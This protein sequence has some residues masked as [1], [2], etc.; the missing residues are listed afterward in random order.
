VT[1]RA[2]ATAL[3]TLAMLNVFTLGAGVAVAGLLPARLA[4]WQVPRVARSRLETPGQV[5]APASPRGPAPDRARLAA[6]LA[7]MLAGRPLGGHVGAVVTDLDTGAVLFSQN[8]GSEF[9]PASNAKL[10]TAV[11]ALSTLGPPARFTTR[12]VAGARPGLLTLVGGGDPTLA[13]GPPPRGDYPR[14]ASQWAVEAAS[15]ASVAGCG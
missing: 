5:L 13:A 10:L 1:N 9:V 11:A 14:P 7:P 4:L 8:A 3:V 2:G 6:L 15:D 12:V